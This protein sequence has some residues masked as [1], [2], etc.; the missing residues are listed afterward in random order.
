MPIAPFLPLLV[1][2]ALPAAVGAPVQATAPETF[3]SAARR[4]QAAREGNRDAEAIGAYQAALAL[5]PEWDEGLWYLGS[6]LYQSGRREEADAAFARFLQVKPQAGPGWVLRGFCAFESGDYKAAAERLHRGLGFGLGGNA[7]LDTLARLRLALALVK[8]YEFE[9]AL[10]PLTILARAA[11]GKPEVVSAVGLA[12]L[13]MA[14]LPSEIPAERLD[15]VQKTGR[16]GALHL[17]DRGSDAERAYA[18]LVAAYPNEPWVHYAQGVFLLRTDSERAV[19]A[20]KAEL[21]VNPRNVFACLD[22]AF[23]L[24]K[25]Q[26]NEEARAVAERA[27]ELSPTLFATHAALGRALVETGEVDRGIRELEQAASLAPESAEVHFALARA[28]ARAGR[29]Q[30]AARERAELARHEQERTARAGT[31]AAGPGEVRP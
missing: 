25:L 21:Q 20:L 19:A 14:L 9:L 5:R 1:L 11:P 22:I 4:A 8:T 13:R 10:Q 27:V 18:E 15:L 17:A 31:A 30:E 29:E 2:L 24:L 6:L 23:E 3:E 12:L 16:A 7:E 28:Y 26:R